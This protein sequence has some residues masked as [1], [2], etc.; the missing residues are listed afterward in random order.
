MTRVRRPINGAIVK[1][2][3]AAKGFAVW[4]ERWIVDG[5]TSSP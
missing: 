1:R 3:D 5:S 2:S 4:P